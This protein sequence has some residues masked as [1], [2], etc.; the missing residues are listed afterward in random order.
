MLA[1]I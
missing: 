1:V